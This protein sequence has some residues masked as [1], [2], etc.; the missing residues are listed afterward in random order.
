M[1]LSKIFEIAFGG[2]GPPVVPVATGTSETSGASGKNSLSGI[3]PWSATPYVT[4]FRGRLVLQ[5]QFV[6]P[7]SLLLNC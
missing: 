2:P 1:P 3:G 7:Q 4:I 5:Q 6:I